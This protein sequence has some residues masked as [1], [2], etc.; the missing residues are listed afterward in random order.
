MAFPYRVHEV[1][2]G[3]RSQIMRQ[4][5]RRDC[6]WKRVSPAR[7]HVTVDLRIYIYLFYM[8]IIA[9]ATGSKNH[10][11]PSFSWLH[12]LASGPHIACMM[13]RLREIKERC[14]DC[15]LACVQERCGA[16][17]QDADHAGGA[18]RLHHPNGARQ[19]AHSRCCVTPASPLSH[20]ESP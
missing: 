16:S 18:E 13:T 8:Y 4:R 3:A 17:R 19:S 15:A 1:V 11:A 7:A 2:C 14:N 20:P 10:K 12:R 6:Q 9:R 5:E